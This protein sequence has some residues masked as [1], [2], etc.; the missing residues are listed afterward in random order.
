MTFIPDVDSD[1][2]FTYADC[3]GFLDNRGP[4]I[5][6]ANAVNIKS[7]I[8]CASSVRVVVLLNHAS[9][10]ADRGRGIRDLAKIL[11]DLFGDSNQLLHNARS[12]RLGISHV[13]KVDGDGEAIELEHIRDM[14][15]DTAGMS[16]EMV[17]CMA[18]LRDRIFVYHPSDNG[19]S[20]WLTREQIIESIS[21][22][23]SITDPVSIFRTVLTVEDEKVRGAEGVCA[24][25]RLQAL[26][27]PYLSP[28]LIR[29]A[30]PTHLISPRPAPLQNLRD[31]VSGLGSR[32]AEAMHG[33]RYLDAA[34]GLKQMDQLTVIDNVVVERLLEDVKRQVMTTSTDVL[35]PPPLAP[36]APP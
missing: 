21:E 32:V 6:I 22:L 29:P 16:D 2:S 31:I 35:Q 11:T 3:P 13:P 18:E 23:E 19:N 17:Q 12:I 10:M 36:P 27:K 8:H 14:M 34:A 24:A 9:L 5:N 25:A 4:E 30:T 20:T 1:D 15:S 26:Y 7:M 28:A 33:Q